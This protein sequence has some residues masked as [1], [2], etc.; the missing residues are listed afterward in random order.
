MEN[1]TEKQIKYIWSVLGKKY[2]LHYEDIENLTK[3]EASGIIKRN[4]Q[5]NRPLLQ[6]YCMAYEDGKRCAKKVLDIYNTRNMKSD[7][8]YL[9]K[10]LLEKS[11]GRKLEDYSWDCDL[12]IKKDLT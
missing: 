2:G 3:K 8:C 6:W 7:R 9:N 12:N 10:R 5:E 1:I 11:M 4:I